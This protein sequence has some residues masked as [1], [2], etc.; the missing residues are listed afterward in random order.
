MSNIEE[1]TTSSVKMRKTFFSPC[2][3]H[4]DN[5]HFFVG[6]IFDAFDKNHFNIFVHQVNCRGVMGGGIARIV[7]QKFPFVFD[8]Y[9]N[10]CASK[11]VDKLFGYTQLVNISNDYEPKKIVAN[12][13]GQQLY[14][15]YCRQTN[16]EQFYNALVDMEEQIEEFEA[17]FPPESPLLNIAFP[18]NIGCGLAGGDFRIVLSMIESVFGEKISNTD[19]LQKSRR[20]NFFI[21]PDEFNKL[22]KD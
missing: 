20:V 17:D 9:Q 8:Q 5:F 14:G 22:M 11:T 16:Y 13:F 6:D 18:Y 15:T 21:L 3:Y 1:I 12:L 4:P 10:L 2:E 19:D 7:K